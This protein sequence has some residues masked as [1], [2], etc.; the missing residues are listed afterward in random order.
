MKNA[1]FGP[2][3]V[4]LYP[5]LAELVRSHG[6]ALAIHGSLARDFDLVCIPWTECPSPPEVV[7]KDITTKYAFKELPGEPPPTKK[8]HGR[9]CY[10]LVV[11]FGECFLDLSFMPLGE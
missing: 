1:N 3:Y 10:T 6:Y 9:L 8:L 4:C 5:E 11:D 7:V 2:V